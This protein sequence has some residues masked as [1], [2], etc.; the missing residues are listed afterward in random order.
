MSERMSQTDEFDERIK[1]GLGVIAISFWC[2]L[3][4]V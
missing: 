1:M 4:I 3:H 2:P